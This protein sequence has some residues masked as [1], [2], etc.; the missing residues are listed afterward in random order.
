VGHIAKDCRL[1]QKIKNQSI[2]KESDEEKD[3]K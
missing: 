2:Q 3:D 1:G